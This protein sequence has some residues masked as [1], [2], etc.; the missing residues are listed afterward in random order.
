MPEDIQT[1][2]AL[3][4]IFSG[5]AD[6]DC[7]FD[8]AQKL[9]MFS[10][11]I[12]AKGQTTQA[13]V[14]PRTLDALSE[15]VRAGTDAGYAV[16]PRGG[17]MSYTSGYTPT[18]RKSIIVDMSGLDEII[19]IN[20]EDMYVTVQAGCTWAKLNEALKPLGLRTP[21]WGTLSGLK[22][23]IG[24]SL[25]QNS[26]FLGA[27]QYGTSAESVIALSVVTAN[28]D[29]IR[30][31]SAGAQDENAPFFRHY[32][33][34]LTGMFLGDA[35]ALGFKA[36][37]TLK[38]IPRPEHEAWGSFTFTDKDAMIRAMSEVSR[39]GLASEMFGFDPN[40]QRVRMKR[41]SLASD[42]ATL[43]KVVKNQSSIV[44]GLVEGAKIAMAG[45]D[46]LDDAAYSCHFAIEGRNASAVKE[47]AETVSKILSA[48]GGEETENSIPKII[49]A[50]PFAPLNNMLG[51]EGER[52]VP[53]HGIVPHSK[54]VAC[55]TAIDALFESRKSELE[56]H[57]ILTGYL[58]LTQA[59]NTFLIEPV[60]IWPEEI[61]AI[62]KASVE[63]DHLA[64]LR[65]FDPNPDATALVE[66][67]RKGVVDV[68]RTYGGVHYQI[69]KTYPYAQ[70]RA[71]ETLALIQA[72]KAHL[73]PKG[74]INPGALGLEGADS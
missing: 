25:S 45:R 21:F 9:E 41:A 40:L 5:V 50:T 65:E 48:A 33:P 61:F 59:T 6:C 52:W 30:T 29:I 26:T 7:I 35:G 49:R 47:N 3:H 2:T 4:A 37:A 70:T 51:P 46:F 57:N 22:A 44:K 31:G 43:A 55:W 19:E 13:I 1:Q 15:V 34:D 20:R 63:P 38:L 32:G 58:V 68:F 28:G 23:S 8:D 12:W 69:G 11:D 16:Y 27:G 42:A 39:T 18:T 10:Q 54:A 36:E 24:G 53:I 67:L 64:R 62:H 60:F 17:G 71:P 74:L 73:D 66:Q 14:C 56:H 72:L